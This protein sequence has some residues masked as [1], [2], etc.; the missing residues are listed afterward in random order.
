MVRRKLQLGHNVIVDLVS[1]RAV[2]AWVKFLQPSSDRL[3]LFFGWQG[4]HGLLPRSCV[5][6][7]G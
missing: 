1:D 7:N 4:G 6:G 5:R 3:D 2:K